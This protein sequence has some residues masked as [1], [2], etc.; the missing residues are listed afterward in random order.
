MVPSEPR[1]GRDCE[2]T[3]QARRCAGESLLS[4]KR[5]RTPS[6]E[7][8]CFEQRRSWRALEHTTGCTELFTAQQQGHC[9][10]VAVERTQI[11]VSF[12]GFRSERGAASTEIAV[13]ERSEIFVASAAGFPQ[14]PQI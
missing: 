9:G 8:G 10:T 1:A 4:T 3:A 6:V 14:R 13:D 12:A 2:T 11:D 7:S 5:S